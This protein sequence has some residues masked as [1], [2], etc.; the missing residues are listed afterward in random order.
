[1]CN[2]ILEIIKSAI[3]SNLDNLLDFG[4]QYKEIY[5]RQSDFAKAIFFAQ[6]SD[7]LSKEDFE[8]IFIGADALEIEYNKNHTETN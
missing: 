3:I 4:I 2:K 6:I 8:N 7:I 5:D 1:M